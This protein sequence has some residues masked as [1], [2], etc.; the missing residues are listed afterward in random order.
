[1]RTIK[2]FFHDGDTLTTQINGTNEEIYAHYMGNDFNFGV[3]NDVVKTAI[4]VDF[5]DLTPEQRRIDAL[6]T[7]YTYMIKNDNSHDKMHPWLPGADCVAL[8]TLITD[9][10]SA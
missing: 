5:L 1:M 6:S 8:K 2:V 3:E 4:A 10:L 7:I 9:V